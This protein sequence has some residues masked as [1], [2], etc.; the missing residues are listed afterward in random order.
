MSTLI[1][2]SHTN[3]ASKVMMLDTEA[4]LHTVRKELTASLIMAP[5][6]VFLLNE[7]EV[8]N[9]QEAKITLSWIIVSNTIRIGLAAVPVPDPEAGVDTYRALNAAQRKGLFQN[10]QIFRGLTFRENDGFVKTFKDLYT[11]KDGYMPDANNP[12]VNTSVSSDY[13]FSKVTKELKLMETNSAS[14]SLS[15]PYGS[16]ETEFKHE[17]SKTT[18]ST[19]VKEYLMSR[20]VVRKVSLHVDSNRIQANED[21]VKAVEK[22]LSVTGDSRVKCC[23]LLETLNEYGYYIPLD[24][25]LGGSLYATEETTISEFSKAEEEKTE[26]SASFKGEFEKIGGGA[27]YKNASGSSQTTTTST[28]YKNV[29]ILQVG[30]IAGMTNDYV[31][32]AE[33]LRKAT[34][35]D[36][37]ATENLYPSLMLLTCAADTAKGNQLLSTCLR[38]FNETRSLPILKTLQP[39]LDIASYGNAIEVLTDP[40]A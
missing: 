16:G 32:W 15:T 34:H 35:W 7:T 22:A 38:I 37:V 10:I 4:A 2:V 23:K 1:T 11:W 24:F 29:H 39:F 13:A 6:D 25:S 20:F 28:K 33:S 19:N 14:L 21:F 26:F 5:E 18:T 8:D 36:V 3:G 12:R 17:K 27:A 9:T 30:G 31:K 40:W